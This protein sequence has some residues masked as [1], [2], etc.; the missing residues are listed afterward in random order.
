MKKIALVATFAVIVAASGYVITLR[1]GGSDISSDTEKE[2]T[3]K[4]KGT[5]TDVNNG[6]WSDGTCSIEVDGKW[7]IAII[8]GGLR[9]PGYEPEIRGDVVGIVFNES[10][11]SLGKEVE[12]YAKKVD[13]ISFTVFGSKEYYVRITRSPRL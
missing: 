11:D 3:V 4:F 1:K 7:W 10:N 8:E 13:E 12:V 2:A 9:A 6:C 5:I